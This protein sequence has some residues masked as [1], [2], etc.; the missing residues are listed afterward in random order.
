MESRSLS[1]K[2][3]D[4]FWDEGKEKKEKRSLGLWQNPEVKENIQ[5]TS[6]TVL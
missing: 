5:L 6:K 2:R 1:V 4:G 3:E